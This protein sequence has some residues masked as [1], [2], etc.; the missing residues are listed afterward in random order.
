MLIHG[1]V[2]MRRDASGMVKS[3][4]SGALAGIFQ[5][6]KGPVAA[7]GQRMTPPRGWWELIPQGQLGMCLK[8]PA[9]EPPMI[10]YRNQEMAPSVLDDMLRKAWRQCG[11]PALPFPCVYKKDMGNKPQTNACLDKAEKAY[12]QGEKQ[13]DAKFGSKKACSDAFSQCLKGGKGFVACS[14]EVPCT[15]SQAFQGHLECM[16]HFEAQRNQAEELCEE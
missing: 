13:C 11:L 10:I 3:T 4:E 9:G 6:N 2:E 5:R 15:S 8:D 7:R 1:N 16:K 14:K 12:L